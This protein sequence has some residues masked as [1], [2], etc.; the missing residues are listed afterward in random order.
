MNEAIEMIRDSL[1]NLCVLKDK[2]KKDPEDFSRKQEILKDFENLRTLLSDIDHKIS[3]NFMMLQGYF[4][5]L[6]DMNAPE[7]PSSEETIIESVSV[8]TKEDSDV[9]AE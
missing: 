1:V 6:E 4:Q 9:A 3:D 2:F 5:A 7:Q 8:E